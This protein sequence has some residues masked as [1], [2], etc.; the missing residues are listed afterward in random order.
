MTSV[1]FKIRVTYGI[2]KPDVIAVTKQH[3]KLEKKKYI[4]NYFCGLEISAKG[5]W[6]T[7]GI[8]K[9]NINKLKETF[10][11]KNLKIR[12]VYHMVSSKSTE[13]SK[14]QGVS[15]YETNRKLST[16]IKDDLQIIGSGN[17]TYSLT[18]L[19]EKVPEYYEYCCKENLRITGNQAQYNNYNISYGKKIRLKKDKKNLKRREQRMMK[20]KI[21]DEY[22]KLYKKWP[23]GRINTGGTIRTRP[24]QMDMSGALV[25]DEHD[26]FKSLLAIEAILNVLATSPGI[27]LRRTNAETYY[28]FLLKLHPGAYQETMREK[29]N[30]WLL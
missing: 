8:F 30:N 18:P 27:T 12:T 22:I 3:E 17:K 20:D 24:F 11:E 13:V 2:E 4:E 19:L 10:K 9:L 21:K 29:V 6:H 15:R 26:A 1:H 28:Q 25:F 7:Q 16:L 5:I 14:P 23:A